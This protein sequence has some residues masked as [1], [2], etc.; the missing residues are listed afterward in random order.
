MVEISSLPASKPLSKDIQPANFDHVEFERLVE[1]IHLKFAPPPTSEPPAKRR[2]VDAVLST[3]P[4]VVNSLS[5]L[6]G[7]SSDTLESLESTLLQRF[8]GLNDA[9]RC[10]AIDLL[11]HVPCAADDTLVPVSSRPTSGL[12][13]SY[14]PKTTESEAQPTC[15]DTVAKSTAIRIFMKIIQLPSFL[16]SRRPRV[17]AMVALKKIILHSR[18][19]ELLDLETSSPG[20]WCL[21]SLQSSLRELRISAGRTLA[22]F[23]RAEVGVSTEPDILMRNKAN[24]LGI[25]KSISD[26]NV[27]YLHESCIMAWGQVGRVVF[28]EELALVLTKL[29]DYLGHRN[30]MVSALSFNEVLNLANHRRTITRKLFEPFWRSLAFSAVKD[31]VSRPQTVRLL[32]E[33]LKMSVNDL[34]LLIQ[35][36]A[37]PYLVLTKKRDVIQRIA[38]ARGEKEPWQP[39]LDAANMSSIMAL[40]LAQ[41]VPDVEEFSL[42]LL[43]HVSP[44]F[45]SISLME[46]LTTEP[47]PTALELLKASGEMNESR[48]QLVRAALTMVASMLLNGTRDVRKKG[49]H[50]VGKFFEQ[51]ALGL[52]ARLVEVINDTLTAHPPIQEQRRCIAAMEEMIKLGKYHV[53]IARPQISASLLSAL[54][55]DELRRAAFSCW[56]ALL[57]HMEEEDVEVL[58]ETTFFIIGHYWQSLDDHSKNA[59]RELIAYLLGNHQTVLKEMVNKLPS[60][61]HISE[62]ADLEA[63]LNRIR[64]P[65]DNRAAFGLFAE[66][67]GHE[68]SGVV[69]QALRELSDYLQ[70]N[71][72]Y[73]QAAAISEQ[74]DS[75]ITVLYRTLLDCSFKYNGVQ[76]DISSLCAKCIGLVGCLDSNRIETV[77]EQKNFV[78]LHNFDNSEET[79]DFVLFLLSEVLVKSFLS[80]TD[81]SVQGFLS[82]A[83][84]EL[85]ERCDFKM[86][87]AKQGQEGPGVYRKWLSL[88]ETTREVLTPFMTSRYRLNPMT[89]PKMEYPIFRPGKA[90][91]NWMRHFVLDLLQKGQNLFAQIIFEPLCRVIRVKDVSIAEFLLPYLFMHITVAEDS[92]EMERTNTLNE[93]LNIIKQEPPKH[94]S[95]IEREEMKLYSEVSQDTCFLLHPLTHI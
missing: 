72:S 8:P 14:C 41:E 1:D 65:L 88:P 83:M 19:P 36:H 44:H 16:E 76:S 30:T 94:A 86:A 46:I 10:D 53:R 59:S 39:C 91:A 12:R 55:Y 20:Q 38:E 45:S 57:T 42:S 25:L 63:K 58:I 93:L 70:H 40:L 52:T 67:L 28:D 74:P 6:V 24:A 89:Q 71:Q 32:A 66:R 5:E 22:L 84:Q 17:A 33:L 13:C 64:K 68:N 48:K 18:D 27:A 47:V 34:L 31:M 79:T 49:H 69:Q 15:R 54:T 81:T 50:V 9:E 95:Y 56:S 35:T 23:L 90:Y 87:V 4:S 75:I 85:L 82:Y 7:T 2:K 37:L 62:L 78:V 3:L 92:S 29:L 43:R 77:R 60:V 51:H 11:A 73:L 61:A 80:A 26:K 21:Q